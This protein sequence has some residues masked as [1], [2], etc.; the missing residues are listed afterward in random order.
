MTK[1]DISDDQTGPIVL[2]GYSV[3]SKDLILNDH[4]ELFTEKTQDDASPNQTKIVNEIDAEEDCSPEKNSTEVG[5]PT[6]QQ[7]V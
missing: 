7:H 3:D 6:T 5:S 1:L 2:E 4:L